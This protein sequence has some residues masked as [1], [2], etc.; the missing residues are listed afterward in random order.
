MKRAPNI[1]ELPLKLVGSNH[2]GRYPQISVEEKFNFIASDNWMVPSAGYAKAT[3]IAGVSRGLFN[4]SKLGKLIQVNDNCVYT[5]DSSLAATK[6]AS[7]NTYQ[8]DVYIEE[9]DGGLI[10]ISDRKYIYVYDP[11]AGTLVLPAINSITPGPLAF[12]NGYIM[13]PIGGRAEWQLSPVNHPEQTW[14]A[15]AGARGMFQTKPDNVQTIVR[16]PGKGNNI[17][18]MGSTVTELWCDTG[19][20]LFPFNRSSGFNIDY[21]CASPNTVASS[22]NF[23][24]WLGINEKSGPVI[25]CSSGCD[26]QQLSDDGMNFKMSRLVNPTNSYGCLYKQDGH[27]I[28]MLTFVDPLDNVTYAYDFNTKGF[29]TFTDSNLNHHIA[30]KVVYFNNDYYFISFADGNLYEL[31]S[32]YTDYDGHEIPR[33]II[34]DTLRL[35]DS[36]PF[37]GESFSFW[38]EQGETRITEIV[39][40]PEFN[41][42]N[43]NKRIDVAISNDGGAS[44][45]NYSQIYLN[46]I[47]HRRNKVNFRGLG[48]A[49][50]LVLQIRF[51]GFD[52]FVLTD[53]ILNIYQ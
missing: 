36:S 49:N 21:G 22:D 20:Q 6:V 38:L 24:V 25:L 10:T 17:F 1:Q 27:L 34:T 39:G 28:Y 31:N 2:F 53:G 13:T 44:F 8:G 50:E 19:A 9:T 51:Y 41:N 23:V 46:E 42:V 11:V 47:G 35:P 52:R 15:G 16:L 3:T 37:V 29:F 48:Y 26:V 5:I 12:L 18:V 7:L 45:G 32:D 43:K 40:Q 33:I 4:S 30:K 14:S